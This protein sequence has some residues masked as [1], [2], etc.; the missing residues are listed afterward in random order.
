M[1]LAARSAGWHT[2]LA[3]AGRSAR[4]K[5]LGSCGD[6]SRC[7]GRAGSNDMPRNASGEASSGRP[8]GHRLDRLDRKAG[9]GDGREKGEPRAGI[10][11]AEIVH[12]AEKIGFGGAR[13]GRRRR[14]SRPRRC[15]R[16]CADGTSPARGITSRRNHSML[17]RLAVFQLET[18]EDVRAAG[19]GRHVRHRRVEQVVRRAWQQSA[20][21]WSSSA[22]RCSSARRRAF[23]PVRVRASCR[24]SCAAEDAAGRR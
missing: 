9:P 23:P 7:G 6:R 19:P 22:L 14:T 1:S 2:G 10:E 16:R 11:R 13:T 15:C 4:G 3:A 18:S 8:L 24:E 5:G 21:I 12:A 20:E 17:S